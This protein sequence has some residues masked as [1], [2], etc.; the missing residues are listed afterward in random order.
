MRLPG[1]YRCRRWARQAR[2]LVEARV[3]VLLYHRVAEPPA[4]PQLLCVTPQR[5]AEQMEEVR[6]RYRVLRVSELAA[7][8]RARRLPHRAVVVTFD[9]GYVDNLQHAA[10]V[11]RQ[12]E[13]PAMVFVA[14]GD[15]DAG[16]RFWWDEL[17]RALLEPVE[18]PPIIAVTINGTLHRWE[19]GTAARYPEE[20]RRR[21]REWSVADAT[22]PTPRHRAYRELHRLLRPLSPAQRDE[23]VNQLRRQ[24]VAAAPVQPVAR[25]VTRAELC[26][27]A[28]GGLIEI[29][30]HTVNH[31][32]LAALPRDVQEF[33]TRESKR[34]LET[35]LGVRVAAF[36][37]PYGDP[38]SVSEDSVAAVRAASYELAFMNV[39]AAVT[40]RTDHYRIP[41][42]QVG[43]WR[44]DELAGQLRTWF[45]E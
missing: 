28:A 42:Y 33:E 24:A 31:P 2:A 29:G 19:L 10:P 18:L 27:L 17:E 6:R 22:D 7:A 37:Y 44:G 39:A 25:G 23:A 30:A 45:C 32:Q 40:H 9:D 5:F 38:A 13:V 3:A 12:L 4:D 21:H 8:L 14:T 11:L 26:Q 20:L 43:N 15:L 36:A 41:R 16:T 1:A 35:L 34:H